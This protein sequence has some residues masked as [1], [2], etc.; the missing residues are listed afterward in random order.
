MDN[1]LCHR[2]GEATTCL[3]QSGKIEFY[4]DHTQQHVGLDW[5]KVGEGRE[6]N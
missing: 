2:T 5:K 4:K 1:R 3:K 6:T